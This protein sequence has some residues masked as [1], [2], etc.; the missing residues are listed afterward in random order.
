MLTTG[1]INTLSAKWVTSVFQLLSC[2]CYHN[3]EQRYWRLVKTIFILYGWILNTLFRKYVKS[4]CLTA[5]LFERLACKNVL[6][7]VVRVGNVKLLSQELS[8]SNQEPID[9]FYCIWGDTNP[10]VTDRTWLML[11]LLPGSECLSQLR[12]LYSCP[13]YL[14]WKA[15]F[16][17]VFSVWSMFVSRVYKAKLLNIHLFKTGN[18]DFLDP[19]NS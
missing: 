19:K 13:F 1:S 15:A 7:F 2:L 8:L 18:S 14:E 10:N 16:Y 4:K 3:V 6:T 11:S 17:F 9:E 12:N 5:F